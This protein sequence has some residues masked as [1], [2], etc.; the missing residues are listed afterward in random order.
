MLSGYWHKGW[1]PTILERFFG[2]AAILNL[3][4]SVIPDGSACLQSALRALKPG[5][6]A[7]I[8]DKFLTE[9]KTVSPLRKIFNFFSTMFGTDINRRLSDL[10]QDCFLRIRDS[11]PLRGSRVP[12]HGAGRMT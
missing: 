5:E 8:L 7:V 4:L 11:S 10:M 2:Y 9:G 3:I 12:A 6:R 1:S